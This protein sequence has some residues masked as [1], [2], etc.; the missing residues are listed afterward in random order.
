MSLNSGLGRRV[1]A[2]QA[3]LLAVGFDQRD[4]FV[5]ATGELEI[6]E[7][8][9]IDG[10]EA[11][12]RAVFG[13]HVGDGGAIGN[14]E[15]GKAGA[16]ELDELADDAFFAQHLGDGENEIGGGRAFAELAVQLEADDF[17]N[18]HRGR[19]AEHG[20]FGFDAAD[21]PAEDAEPVDHGGV[22][23]GA[24]HGIGIGLELVAD[25][26]WRRRRARDIRD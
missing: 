3:L 25:S 8:F 22:R 11:H 13:R 23:I 20:G 4:L 26:A 12:G 16:V 19:L 2:E 1:G 10:E 6:R 24:D 21:A 5:R 18:Q 15:A 7:R 9:G 14:A 17:G